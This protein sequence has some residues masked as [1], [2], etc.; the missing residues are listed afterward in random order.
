MNKISFCRFITILLGFVFLIES[1]S[2]SLYNDETG[3]NIPVNLTAST[4]VEDVTRAS[5]VL[6]NTSFLPE[7]YIN[8]YFTPSS[9][10]MLLNGG[11]D[12]TSD[13]VEYKTESAVNGV[14]VISPQEPYLF[15]C[16]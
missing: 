8:V 10:H 4:V 7:R 13:Y 5:A 12:L 3:Q 9:G 11:E 2:D 16:W 1:C 15:P 6:Q 14:N